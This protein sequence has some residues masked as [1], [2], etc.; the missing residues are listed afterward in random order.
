VRI[1]DG[2]RLVAPGDAGEIQVRGDFIMLGYWRRDEATAEAIDSNGW[3]HTGD[4]AVERADGRYRLIGRIS[5]MYKSGGYNVY[6]KEVEGAIEELAGVSAV[7]VVGLP[8]PLYGETGHAFIV[9]ENRHAINAAWL[10]EACRKQLANY[11]IPRFFH[12]V[13]ELP[14]LPIGKVDKQALRKIATSL[15]TD[16]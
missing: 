13:N 10:R 2:D 7:A 11:K 5:E 3:L 8:D 6:P 1:V 14:L 4:L 9:A 12:F 16:A 15:E